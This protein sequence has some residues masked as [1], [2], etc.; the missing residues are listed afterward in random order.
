MFEFIIFLVVA[1]VLVIIIGSAKKAASRKRP[2]DESQEE[3]YEQYF[4]NKRL[5]TPPELKYLITLRKAIGKEY[6]IMGKV[7]V[8][9]VINVKKNKDY[10]AFMS[11]FG[12]IKSKHFDF[13]LCAPRTYEPIAAI[14]L[15]DSSHN[16]KSR[17]KRD[18]FLNNLCEAKG[19]P[20]IR[21][22]LAAEYTIEDVNKKVYGALGKNKEFEIKPNMEAS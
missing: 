14:E 15:D 9:D 7:R 4:I 17:Q 1:V 19:F 16:S 21:Q 10:S 6:H 22:K 8:A 13:V 20:L 11:A 2:Q 5:F 18:E 3:L 12:K